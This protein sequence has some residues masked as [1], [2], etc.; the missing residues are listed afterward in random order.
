MHLPN[1]EKFIQDDT[2]IGILSR[3]FNNEE[4]KLNKC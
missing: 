1:G 2:A 4:D 3:A